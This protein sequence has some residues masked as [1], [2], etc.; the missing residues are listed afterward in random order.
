MARA[1]NRLVLREDV[2]VVVEQRDDA[3]VLPEVAIEDLQA[4]QIGRNL[5]TLCVWAWPMR[6]CLT[7]AVGVEHQEPFVAAA[8]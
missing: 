5:P 4:R 8:E 6:T 7:T 1:W 3:R 2:A